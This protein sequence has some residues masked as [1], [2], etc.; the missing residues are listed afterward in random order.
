MGGE[1]ADG[2][3]ALLVVGGD[4]HDERGAY[5]GERDGIE[6]FILRKTTIGRESGQ[7]II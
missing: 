7:R 1:G 3:A 2:F 4:V 5:V 6:N